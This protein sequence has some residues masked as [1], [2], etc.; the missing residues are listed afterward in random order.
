[1]KA[2]LLSLLAAAPLQAAAAGPLQVLDC[3][4]AIASAEGAGGQIVLEGGTMLLVDVA[5]YGERGRVEVTMTRLGERLSRVVIR[6]ISYERSVAEGTGTQTVTGE[7]NLLME[8]SAACTAEGCARFEGAVDA[9]LA[10]QIYGSV[11]A[12][13]AAPGDC[14]PVW[15]P[16][17]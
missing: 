12:A 3:R 4:L 6:A 14:R 2:L 1:M 16:K 15:P 17:G 8:G 7:A 5:V 13:L 9:D 10:M 11:L